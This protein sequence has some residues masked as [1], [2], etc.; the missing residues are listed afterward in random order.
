MSQKKALD[1]IKNYTG[2]PLRIMEVC[3][4]HTHA[5]FRYGIRDI[6]PENIQLISGPGCPV[7]VTETNYIDEALYL[8]L[9]KS[10]SI[11]TFGDLIRVPGERKNLADART[12]SA[13]IKIVYSPIDAYQFAKDHPEKQV[14]FLSVGFETTTPASCLAV[15]KAKEDNLTNFSLLTAN[16]IMD[17]A[18]RVLK[19]SADAFLYPGHVS[20][21]TGMKIYHELKN[22]GISGAVC[23]F[24]A[25]EILTAL[26]VIINRLEKGK[27]F[28]ENCYSRVVTEN[29]APAARALIS[30][31]MEPCDAVWRGIGN[32]SGSGMKLNDQYQDYDARIKYNV[33]KI[34][35]KPNPGCRCGDVLMGKIKPIECPLFKKICTPDN[36]TG[37]C[38][39]SNEGTCAAYYK[40]GKN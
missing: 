3:G 38:M 12:E 39:V 4:T 31:V 1:I 21:I 10:V 25:D 9:E 11:T 13:E 34:I 29:G 28:A 8:A 14:V 26:A 36:P 17:P 37:A 22:E 15:K 5:I 18:Y 6:L 16:K 33:P 24:T 20:A 27:P 30:E 32:I 40:Y 35:S 2:R 7:C 23:G 19:G